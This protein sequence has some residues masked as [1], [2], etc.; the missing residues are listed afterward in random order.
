[1]WQLPLPGPAGRHLIRMLQCLP[2]HLACGEKENENLN[3]VRY[4]EKY[5]KPGSACS[6]QYLPVY[7]SI[8]WEKRI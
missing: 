8:F 2:V 4:G 5:V 1:M 3:M 6:Y 7:T